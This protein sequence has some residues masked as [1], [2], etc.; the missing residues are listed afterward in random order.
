VGLNEKQLQSAGSSIEN[1]KDA[2]V[3]DIACY[4]MESFL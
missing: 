4:L 1:D 2:K 3:K